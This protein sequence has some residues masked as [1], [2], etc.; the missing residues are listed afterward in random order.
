MTTNLEKLKVQINSSELSD[1][2][3]KHLITLFSKA[4]NKDL[5]KVV[6]LFEED[7][8]WIRKIC[9]NYKAKLLTFSTN[10]QEGWQKLLL[11]EYHTVSQL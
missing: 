4:K 2:E 9:D 1:S 11:E 8:N 5:E 6:I 10:D 3:Q 7:E